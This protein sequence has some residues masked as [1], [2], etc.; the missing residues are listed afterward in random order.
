MILRRNLEKYHILSFQYQ[1][2]I[3]PV[4]TIYMLGA[5]LGSLLYGDVSVIHAVTSKGPNGQSA[6]KSHL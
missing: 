2:Q 3:S 1:P 6:N 4:S 5:N